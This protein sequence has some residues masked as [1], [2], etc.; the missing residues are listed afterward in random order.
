MELLVVD[1]H[2][3]FR[4]SLCQVLS[5]LT[6]SPLRVLQAGDGGEA[7]KIVRAHPDLALIL[8]DLGLPG[9]DGLACLHA[10]A[11]Q[12]PQARILIVSGEVEPTVIRQALGAGARGY[13]PKDTPVEVMLSAL[14]L[15]LSGGTYLP[16]Q[17]LDGVPEGGLAEDIRLSPRQVEI[18]A[19][20]QE[21]L[22]NKQIAGRLGLSEST[23]KV[24]I[25]RIFTLLG[26]RNRSQAVNLA[27]ERGIL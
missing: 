14:K 9:M 24:H 27:R 6:E 12:V 1:D 19:L 26:A 8:L 17:L 11:A 15:V 10:L 2:T 22:L 7:L 23:V 25:R 5:G 13:I 3:L 16:A 20:L 18:L 4:E 21:G